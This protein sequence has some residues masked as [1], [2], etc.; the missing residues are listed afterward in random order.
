MKQV[1][2]FENPQPKDSR[3][4]EKIKYTPSQRI[5]DKMSDDQKRGVQMWNLMRQTL[6]DN[7]LMEEK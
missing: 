4:Q 2:G 6:L 7:G 5:N 1:V 3:K